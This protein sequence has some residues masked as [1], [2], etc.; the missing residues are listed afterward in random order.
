MISN[1]CARF[2]RAARVSALPGLGVLP[3]LSSPSG[4][5]HERTYLWCVDKFRICLMYTR[6]HTVV[7][8]GSGLDWIKVTCYSLRTRHQASCGMLFFTC[9]RLLMVYWRN[10]S[11][12]PLHVQC[13]HGSPAMVR[14]GRH[15]GS[16]AQGPFCGHARTALTT[17]LLS[18]PSAYL[19]YPM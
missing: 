11:K 13:Q 12:L 17:V 3:F 10:R 16:P 8:N 14:G 6:L 9:R 5:P 19:H 4:Q 2:R 15:A 18:S 1:I 7:R